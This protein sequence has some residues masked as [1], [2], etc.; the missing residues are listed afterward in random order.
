DILSKIAALNELSN[1]KAQQIIALHDAMDGLVSSMPET[2]E[3]SMR[4]TW[5]LV[6]EEF[7][8]FRTDVL[9]PFIEYTDGIQS[10]VDRQLYLNTLRIGDI[11]ALSG[12][13]GSML[14]KVAHMLEPFRS[15]QAELVGWI[16]GLGEQENA[17]V[18]EPGLQRITREIAQ[19]VHDSIATG[20]FPATPEL[21]L[22]GVQREAL[23]A[24]AFQT[25]YV[26]E[27]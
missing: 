4:L 15:W 2:I 21:V 20:V 19:D 22:S 16:A 18:V 1:G 6:S 27:H 10:V 9:D 23:A 25:W 14:T 24:S 12:L 13:P 26:G 17:A 5:D 3:A 7:T 8:A 11:Q